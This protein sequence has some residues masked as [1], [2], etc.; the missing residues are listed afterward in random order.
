M[1]LNELNRL[2]DNVG[3]TNSQAQNLHR[4]A[5]QLAT[6]LHKEITR[7]IE[8]QRDEKQQIREASNRVP[9]GKKSVNEMNLEELQNEFLQLSSALEGMTDPDEITVTMMRLT[10]IEQCLE[11]L[12]MSELATFVQEDTSASSKVARCYGYCIP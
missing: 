8:G 11:P 4:N 6:N 10:E 12:S 2:S 7:M 3:S 1:V 5:V 9:R